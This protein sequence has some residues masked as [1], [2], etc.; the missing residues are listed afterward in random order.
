MGWEIISP[1]A[2]KSVLPLT[3]LVKCFCLF[4]EKTKCP[5]YR[6]SGK[7]PSEWL[8]K[9]IKRAVYT[10]PNDQRC[11]RHLMIMTNL[12]PLLWIIV[13]SRNCFRSTKSWA[14]CITTNAFVNINKG[15]KPRQGAL[16]NQIK[17]SKY[18]SKME[19]RA[20]KRLRKRICE[21]KRKRLRKQI[22]VPKMHE[23]GGSEHQKSAFHRA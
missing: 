8:R 15:H 22:I 17:P 10:T 20:R 9:H 7:Q 13:A 12:P 5:S 11:T 1:C 23:T 14:C 18:I 21:W 3:V 19:K 2:I 16:Q 6:Q 4:I